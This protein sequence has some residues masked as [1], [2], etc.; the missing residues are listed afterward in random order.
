ML[1]LGIGVWIA[2]RE[3]VSLGECHK[4]Q[5]L[6][7]QIQAHVFKS[8]PWRYHE[9]H[10]PKNTEMKQAREPH[11]KGL[12]AFTLRDLWLYLVGWTR[13]ELATN[14]LVCEL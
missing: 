2:Y 7:T 4:V 10:L 11:K 9:N 5:R 1:V 6:H 13:L 3:A 8:V 14:G 12:S